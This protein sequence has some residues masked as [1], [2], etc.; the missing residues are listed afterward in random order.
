[1]SSNASGTA[2]REA[3]DAAIK[4]VV[5]C[6]RLKAKNA[7]RRLDFHHQESAKLITRFALIGTEKLQISNL[8]RSAKGSP[9][10]KVKQ[11][12]GLNREILDT[13]PRPLPEIRIVQSGRSWCDLSGS[14]NP[15]AETVPDL[16]SLRPDPEKDA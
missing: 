10:K 2:V 16:P 14:A 7:R 8:T 15:Q 9:G 1:M 6:A 12:A 5:R 11:K 13:V 4:A 3:H